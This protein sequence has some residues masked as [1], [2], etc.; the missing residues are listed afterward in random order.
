MQCYSIECIKYI[1]IFSEISLFCF[2]TAI[3]LAFAYIFTLVLLGPLLYLATIIERKPK[4]QGGCPIVSFRSIT[5][6][7]LVWNMY[8]LV[9]LCSVDALFYR[10]L[11]GCDLLLGFTAV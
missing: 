9:T 10:Y 11:V 4:K 5:L 3:A 7:T 1:W 2:E 8:I 6:V